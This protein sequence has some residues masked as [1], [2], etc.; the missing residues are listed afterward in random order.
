MPEGGWLQR[1][2]RLRD[3]WLA[4][5]N[6][7]RWASDFP[8]TRP[9]ARRRS[10]AVFDLVAGFA[11]S[12]ILLACT[13]LDL[14][15]YLAERPRTLPE[16]AEHGALGRDAARRLVDAAVSLRLLEARRDARFGLGPLGAPL[17]GNTALKAMILHHDAFYSDLTDP[18]A[19]LRGRVER[20]RLARYW[21]YAGTPEPAELGAGAVA[22]YSRLMSASLPL[23]ADEVLQAYPLRAH[24][25][26]LD[27]GGGEGRFLDAALHSAPGLQGILFDLPAVIR[28]AALRSDMPPRGSRLRCVG[29][30]FLRDPLPRG[31][32]IATLVRV[33]HDHDDASVLTLLRAVREALPHGGTLL[34]AEPMAG[35][36][37]AETVGD[38]YFGLY[39][40]AMGHGRARTPRALQALLRTAG[41]EDARLLRNATPLQTQVIVARVPS[42]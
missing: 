28:R 20:P 40:L 25:C 27:V 39:L 41:F 7:R 13:R 32:D 33:V 3:G 42:A 5:P 29:G 2:K 30:D 16:I 26:V 36:P 17:V 34:L 19:L 22:E 1:W 14:F 37:G 38:A 31:A 6:F 8:L 15:E 4:N 35:T 10:R 21:P 24:H 11:Y 9:I 23:V 18:V 12:Q